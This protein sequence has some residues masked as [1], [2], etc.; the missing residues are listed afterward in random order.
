[1]INNNHSQRLANPSTPHFDKLNAAL[2]AE[3]KSISTCFNHGLDEGAKPHWMA[4]FYFDLAPG[5]II[6][7]LDIPK[8]APSVVIH[9]RLWKKP[10]ADSTIAHIQSILDKS[11]AKYQIKKG[12]HFGN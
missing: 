8:K 3:F 6:D 5:T 7:L 1:M 11:A 2:T 9:S 4:R 10:V 12:A